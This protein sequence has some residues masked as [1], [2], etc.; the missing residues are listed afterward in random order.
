MDDNGDSVRVLVSAEDYPQ[1]YAEVQSQLVDALAAAYQLGEDTTYDPGGPVP[2]W[3]N[4]PEQLRDALEELGRR[5]GGSA[6]L[7]AHRPGSWEA[8]HVVALAAG[9]DF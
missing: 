5:H 8:V 4:L 7:V 6:T 9:A 2:A 1:R 3:A